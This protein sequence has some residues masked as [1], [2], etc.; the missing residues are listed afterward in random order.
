MEEVVKK[1][2]SKFRKT[3]AALIVDKEKVLLVKRNS[4]PFNGKWI[5]PGGHIEEGE[6]DSDA[7]VREVKE[8][9]GLKIKPEY[10]GNYNEHYEKIG[11][12]AIISVFTVKI[13]GKKEVKINKKEASDFSWYGF[14]EL[15]GLDMGFDHKK[16]IFEYFNLV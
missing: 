2:E 5:M 12:N 8:E 7:V 9:V 3:V 10:F 16:I 1:E 14:D 15:E 13:I 11:W 4:D 6:K